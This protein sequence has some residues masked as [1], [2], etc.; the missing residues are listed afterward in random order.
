MISTTGHH[1][2]RSRLTSVRQGANSGHTW[3]GPG[4]CGVQRGESSGVIGLG[5]LRVPPPSQAATSPWTSTPAI[6]GWLYLKMGSRLCEARGEAP[7][8]SQSPATPSLPGTVPA[9]H[10]NSSWTPLI[11]AVIRVLVDYD[12][13]SLERGFRL[14]LPEM[15]ER[16]GRRG[17]WGGVVGV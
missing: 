12:W 9:P 16:E 17:D 7:P 10:L 5:G 11:C 8:R 6:P 3:W 15:R 1:Q 4:L 14:W 2:A 13:C